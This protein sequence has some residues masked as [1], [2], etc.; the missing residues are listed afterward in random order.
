MSLSGT[1]RYHFTFTSDEM[2]ASKYKIS[3]VYSSAGVCVCFFYVRVSVIHYYKGE[4]AHRI[5][6]IYLLF[7][8]RLSVSEAHYQPG[9]LLCVTTHPDVNTSRPFGDERHEVKKWW[10]DVRAM[11]A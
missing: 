1:P 6:A 5:I 9:G 11:S 4:G 7:L 10:K 2:F 3:G 8:D